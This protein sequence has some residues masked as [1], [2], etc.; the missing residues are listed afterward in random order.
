VQRLRTPGLSFTASVLTCPA[1]EFVRVRSRRAMPEPA[2][3][4]E[5]ASYSRLRPGLARAQ[6]WRGH[7]RP[8][9][10]S[11]FCRDTRVG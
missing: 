6:A 8:S 7:K 5:L 9:A 10:D 4:A 11:I 3:Q 2:G 1:Y